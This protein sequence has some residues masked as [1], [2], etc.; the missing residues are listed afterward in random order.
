MSSPRCWI[1]CEVKALCRWK[2]I[3]VAEQMQPKRT[4]IELFLALQPGTDS[5]LAD[6]RVIDKR[7][8][9]SRLPNRA[10]P[11]I[12][13][14]QVAPSQGFA[15]FHQE[16]Q[17]VTN[18]MHRNNGTSTAAAPPIEIVHRRL[19]RLDGL[20]PLVFSTPVVRCFDC[21]STQTI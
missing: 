16:R 10:L 19:N 20:S 12:T 4:A 8:V 2:E 11:R 9:A 1:G 5:R 13:V 21:G 3:T 14:K 17:L 15:S 7:V 18:R 6:F